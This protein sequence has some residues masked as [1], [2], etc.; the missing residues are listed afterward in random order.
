M[1][2]RIELSKEQNLQFEAQ[3]HELRRQQSQSDQY[4]QKEKGSLQ[5]SIETSS[6]VIRD[7]QN[8]CKL[9]EETNQT[10]QYNNKH[11]VHE[12]D[13]LVKELKH[14]NKDILSRANM[15]EDQVHKLELNLSSEQ[16]MNK[17]LKQNVLKLEKEL[18]SINE[19]NLQNISAIEF[20]L[21]KSQHSLSETRQQLKDIEHQYRIQSDKANIA[22]KELS[23]NLNS[24][25][26]ANRSLK[27]DLLRLKSEVTY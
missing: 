19:I 12:Y 14:T 16:V 9:L 18:L 20:S 21:T 6:L 26:H 7:L 22:Y 15:L 13:E 11:K 17:E 1:Q 23:V 27:D 24:A 8:R 10:E 4:H 5:E 25:E 2:R 3:L